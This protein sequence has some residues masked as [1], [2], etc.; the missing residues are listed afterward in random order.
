MHTILGSN[1]AMGKAVLRVLEKSKLKF[2]LVSRSLNKATSHTLKANLLSDEEADSA[3]KGSNYVYLCVGL[4]YSYRVWGK[5]WEVIMSNVIN[6]CIKYDAKLIFLDN[7]YMYTHDLPVPFYEQTIQEPMSKKGKVRKKV[8]DAFIDAYTNRGLKGLIARSADFYG[9]GATNSVFYLS[10]LER[11]LDGKNPQLLSMGN[12]KHTFAYIDDNAR[13]M[14]EL[15]LC[16]SCYGQIWHL[17]VGSP[18]T[19]DEILEMINGILKTNYK[20]SVM[21]HLLSRTLPHFVPNLKEPLEMQYQFKQEYVMSFDKFKRQFS[22]FKITSNEK[23]IEK[24]VNYFLQE[25]KKVNTVAN[26]TYKQ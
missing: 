17:P 24:T 21:S 22:N 26:K 5:E 15:A 16:D 11:I 13:G 12:V 6:A 25:R 3:I 7:I 14:A 4:P 10:S 20:S 2:R 23:G 9:K 8:A 1:G 18:I 19:M